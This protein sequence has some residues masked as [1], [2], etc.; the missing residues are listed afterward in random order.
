[1]EHTLQIIQSL[2]EKKLTTYPRVDTS[3]LPNDVYKKVPDIL[4]GLT[5][6]QNFIEPILSGGPIRK[7]PKVFNDKKITDHH[8]IIPTGQFTSSMS[9]DEKRVYDMVA[10]R[11]IA[12]FYPDCEIANTIVMAK[13]SDFD[14]KATGKQI[15]NPA[16]RVLY[17][18]AVPKNAKVNLDTKEEAEEE[19]EIKQGEENMLPDYKVGEK[20]PHIPDLQEKETQAPK[21]FTE[22]DLLRAME[23]AGKQVENE[24]LR[25]LMKENGIGR[26][27]TRANIIETLLKR[28]YIQKDKKRLLATPTGIELIDTIDNELLKSAELTGQWEKKLRMISDEKYSVADFMIE[29]KNM[30]AK[31]VDGVKRAQRKT[32]PIFILLLLTSVLGR[33]LAHSSTPKDFSWWDAKHGYDGSK[34]WTEYL[35]YAPGF[36]GPNALPVPMFYNGQIQKESTLSF[37]TDLYCGHGDNTVDL[38]LNWYQTFWDHRIG[39]QLDMVPVEY[40]QTTAEVRDLRASREWD[41]K[42]W[43]GGDLAFSFFFQVIRNRKA[44]DIVLSAGFKTATGN[45]SGAARYFDAPAYHIDINLGK[46]FHFKGFIDALEFGGTLGFLCWQTYYPMHPQN[47]AFMYG[48]RL[49]LVH[50]NLRWENQF[51]GY[52]GYLHNGDSPMIIRTR[53]LWAQNQINYFIQY[54]HGI[55]DY[56]FEQIRIGV[57][58]KF[59]KIFKKN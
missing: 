40:Y 44:P 42:G 29:L 49:D 16:W 11:F 7:S 24:E 6:Y 23:T 50:K 32:I 54:Q 20:G 41:A 19:G 18:K 15:L 22:A 21:Y 45:K 56:P 59:M 2:Y 17:P 47:D 27:S 51:G 25:E 58:W 10:R 55:K 33:T 35:K 14:F 52:V 48:L 34:S 4:K 43:A 26:P 53:F 8:A 36:F 13:V 46:S 5:P 38:Y 28:N 12:V 1:A 30:V 37:A 3:F 31:L 39:V 9:I 57:D